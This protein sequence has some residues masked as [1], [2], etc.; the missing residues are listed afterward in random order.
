MNFYER[1][2]SAGT[3]ESIKTTFNR[4]EDNWFSEKDLEDI[5]SLII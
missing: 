2:V 5:S 3:E 1:C 4:I